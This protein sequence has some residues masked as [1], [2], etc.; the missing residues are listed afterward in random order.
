MIDSSA[1]SGRVDFFVAQRISY[2]LSR[3]LL[4]CA[5]FYTPFTF[6]Q[7]AA[8]PRLPSIILRAGM[9]QIQA[10]VAQTPTER[11][12][13]LMHRTTMATHEGMLF[14]FDEVGI[15]CFWMKNTL[16]PLSVAFL[17]DTGV[18]VNLD[19]MKPQTLHSH[20]SKKAVRFV[21]E[22]NSKWFNNRGLKAGDRLEGAIF[23]TPPK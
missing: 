16:I 17:D 8:Q 6:A 1:I 2:W 4:I 11:M 10:E 13:G 9:H 21:L 15:Q 20:C 12:M 3:V 23:K 22:M 18:I 19:E 14:V 5:Y 7:E